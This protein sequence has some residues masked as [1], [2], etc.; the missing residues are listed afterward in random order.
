MSKE[1][2]AVNE[3]VEAEVSS[4]EH[5]TS[6]GR[7]AMAWAVSGGIALGAMVGGI[8]YFDQ[9]DKPC[10]STT[11]LDGSFGSAGELLT[12]PDG[13]KISFMVFP[14]NSDLDRKHPQ[15]KV[16]AA[17]SSRIIDTFDKPGPEAT[18][19]LNATTQL[20]INAE[21]DTIVTSCLALPAR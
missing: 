4:P 6:R 17:G 8:N 15:V 12:L 1:S 11:T 2:L 9:E 20:I 21:N 5:S 18:I 19:E 13:S 14:K 3:V 7:R 10:E 16:T